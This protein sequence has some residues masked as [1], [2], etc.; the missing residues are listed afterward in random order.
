MLQY[1]QQYQQYG[2]T[3][4][5][6]SAQDFQDEFAILQNKSELRKAALVPFCQIYSHIQ[7][8]PTMCAAQEFAVRILYREFFQNNMTLGI[9]SSNPTELMSMVNETTPF[10]A[11]TPRTLHIP[12]FAVSDR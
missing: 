10:L 5:V 6:A 8:S 1:P 3:L 4:S 11:L 7:T 12:T 2:Q 9:S